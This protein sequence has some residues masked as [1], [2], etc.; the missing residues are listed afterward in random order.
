MLTALPNSHRLARSRVATHNNSSGAGSPA[1]AEAA[2]EQQVVP[3][4]SGQRAV[5]VGA[6]PAGS[7]AAMFLARQGFSVD[8]F[9][10]RPEPKQDAVDTGRAYIIILIPRGQAALKELGVP[11][12]SQREFITKGTVRH[13]R[14]GKVG[15]SREE[16]N[17]TFSRSSLAQYLI[18][19]ARQRYPS[20]ITFHFDSAC[21]GVNIEQRQVSFSAAGGGQV[22]RSYDLLVGA[23][24][25]GSE[26]RRALQQHY[27]DMQVTIDDSGREYKVYGGVRGDI[28]PEEF[29]KDPGATLHLWSSD[30]PWT[31]VT[32]HSNPDGTYSG[33][34]SLKTGGFADLRTA[35]DYEALLRKKFVGVP[36]DWVP[37]IA[38]QAAAATPSPAGKRVRCSRLDGPGVLLLG[39]AAHAVTPVFGQGANSALESCKVLGSVLA[40]AGGDASRVPQLFTSA[41]LADM[42]ALNELD[43]KAY[44][45]FRRRGLLDPD[46]LQLL[47]HVLLGTILSKLVPFLYGPKPALLKLGSTTPYSTI[48]AAVKRDSLMAAVGFAALG[49]WLSFKLAAKVMVGA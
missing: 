3:L 31:T 37:A 29:K 45:F 4:Y 44:S 47:S 17:V 27:P 32:A 13:D 9:E 2:P 49:V 39:D 46:F 34:F 26:V 24:G 30:D 28:E 33:T 40:E 14:K 6:G 22:Q 15:I 43:A 10:R 1:V 21:A 12:P 41:R 20:Q 8:V 18:D 7:T 42:Y 16:G 35:A 38:Q 19:Q 5:V 23:D 48:I 11:L 36:D 25:A